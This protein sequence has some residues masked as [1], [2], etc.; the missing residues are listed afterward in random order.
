[1][2]LRIPMKVLT[3]LVTLSGLGKCLPFTALVIDLSDLLRITLKC[4]S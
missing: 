4:E 1:M 3:L 2:R